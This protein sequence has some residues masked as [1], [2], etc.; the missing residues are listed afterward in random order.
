VVLL[1]LLGLALPSGKAQDQQGLE[2]R[3]TA[4][5]DKLVAVTFNSATN[6]LAITKANLRIVKGLNATDTT[7]GLGNLLV[8][9]NELRGDPRLGPDVRT[10]SHN[11]VVGK[12]D[13]FSSFRG[14]VIGQRNEI[15]GA[16]ASVSG[17]EGN[18]AS[19]RSASVTGGE[20]NTASGEFSSVSGGE[21]NSASGHA[22]SVSAG[23]AN[24]ASGDFS[25]VSGGGG[26]PNGGAE[27]RQ[28][29]SILNYRGVQPHGQ[30]ILM[31]GQWRGS[32]HG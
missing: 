27:Y 32:K 5:E 10:G 13:N 14:V 20:V 16:F 28:R 24:T 17:G 31:L 23:N 21:G 7:N 30:W 12:F 4:L 8:G 25:S 15:S 9:Y 11:V 3:V 2:Q 1:S 26:E 6:E 22:S 19:G 18:M 29:S